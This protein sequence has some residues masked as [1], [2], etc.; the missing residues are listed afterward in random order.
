MSF[1]WGSP[2]K[3][4]PEP[5]AS[6]ASEFDDLLNAKDLELQAILD[7]GLMGKPSEEARSNV[8]NDSMVPSS[9]P[10]SRISTRHTTVES[11]VVATPVVTGL[12]SKSNVETKMWL[13]VPRKYIITILVTISMGTIIAKYMESIWS[14]TDLNEKKF[15]NP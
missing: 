8:G 7:G 12:T 2:T 15:G 1:L 11:G 5:V 13:G 9:A 3:S 10:G 6:V 4:V 14:D